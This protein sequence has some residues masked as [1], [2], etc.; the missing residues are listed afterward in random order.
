MRAHR[1]RV[2]ALKSPIYTYANK[3]L[4]PCSQL[5]STQEVTFVWQSRLSQLLL[6]SLPKC[7]I[8][9]KHGRSWFYNMA[10]LQSCRKSALLIELIHSHNI[11]CH[12]VWCHLGRICMKFKE[13]L[14]S[15]IHFFVKVPHGWQQTRFL[16]D[17]CDFSNNWVDVSNLPLAPKDPWINKFW[18]IAEIFEK[19]HVVVSREEL[20]QI[21]VWGLVTSP[22]V[23][24][25]VI[26]DGG[27]KRTMARSFY[28][29]K[30]KYFTAQYR[31]SYSGIDPNK[32]ALQSPRQHADTISY[33]N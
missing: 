33:V 25:L 4:Q 32:R 17:F 19:P 6:S 2:F 18:K 14:P 11:P 10:L 31:Y 5:L 28:C 8:W 7:C 26:Q 24:C 15:P 29:S 3:P 22:S 9:S 27:Q 23:S 1:N 16:K 21:N 12:G 30:P 20:L 13:R